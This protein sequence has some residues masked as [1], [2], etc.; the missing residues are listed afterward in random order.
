M[1]GTPPTKARRPRSGTPAPPSAP[2]AVTGPGDCEWPWRTEFTADDAVRC[3]VCD[4]EYC[5]PIRLTCI[6][7]GQRNGRVTIDA[8]GVAIDPR[9]PPADRGVRIGI[10]FAC[11]HGHAFERSFHF[12]KGWTITCDEILGERPDDWA[13]IWRA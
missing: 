9:H 8:H 5:H 10:E 7:P 2:S 4:F 1:N 13:T 12:S 3:P 6:S 11:E